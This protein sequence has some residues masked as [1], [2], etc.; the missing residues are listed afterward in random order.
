MALN[1][2]MLKNPKVLAIGG[3]FVVAGVY[4]S[5]KMKN[6]QASDVPPEE[7]TPSTVTVA[8]AD[9]VTAYDQT[10]AKLVDAQQKLDQLEQKQLEEQ[11]R[12]QNQLDALGQDKDRKLAQAGAQYSA[13]IASLTALVNSLKTQ[14]NTKP[15]PP[16]TAQGLKPVPPKTT[17]PITKPVVTPSKQAPIAGMGK[18]V[19]YPGL[20]NN[21]VMDCGKVGYRYFLVPYEQALAQVKSKGINNTVVQREMMNVAIGGGIPNMPSV[22]T[23]GHEYGPDSITSTNRAYCNASRVFCGLRPLSDEEFDRMKAEMDSLWKKGQPM[24]IISSGEYA[25]ILFSHWNA[26]YQ[27]PTATPRF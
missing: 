16:T 3:V 18:V 20:G 19:H 26:P 24:G 10:S 11:N 13:Q 6:K 25:R 23:Y 2:A 4:L 22:A 15:L 9:S 17:T 7:I 27:C 5:S 21:Y 1:T 12:Y 14:I 8:S